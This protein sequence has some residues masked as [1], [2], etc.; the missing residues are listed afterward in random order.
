MSEALFGAVAFA[1]IEPSLRTGDVI[2][3][4]DVE[5]TFATRRS[6]RLLKRATGLARLL[7]FL[8]CVSHENL[9]SGGATG[10]GGDGTDEEDRDDAAVAC[11]LDFEAEFDDTRQAAFVIE[12]IDE[13]HTNPQNDPN[14]LLPFLFVSSDRMIAPARDFVASMRSR[15]PRFALRR[16]SIANERDA[17][18]MVSKRRVRD[19][20][21]Q[22]LLQHCM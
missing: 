12:L 7:S 5:A 10:A 14:K 22:R 19:V 1:Q 8:P 11:R 15:E 6:Q 3:Y 16:L 21:A 13:T 17:Q 2:L 9:R 20:L 4:S 18:H